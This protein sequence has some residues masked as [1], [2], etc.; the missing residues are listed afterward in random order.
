ME[1]QVEKY[2]GPAKNWAVLAEIAGVLC[3]FEL[4][5]E[6]RIG[7]AS[8]LLERELVTEEMKDNF[9]KMVAQF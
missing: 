3:L 2:L 9:A 6:E 8:A 1:R 4:P 7:A 5:A